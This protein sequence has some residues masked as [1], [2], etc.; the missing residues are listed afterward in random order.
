VAGPADTSTGARR[1]AGF[2][3]ATRLLGLAEG[4]TAQATGFA[5]V[6]G[7]E[8]AGELFA[9]PG[10]PTA[11][12]AANDL[13]ALG[14]IEAAEEAGLRCPEDLSVVGF[15]DMPFVDRFRPALTTIRIPEYDIGRRAAAMLLARI[16]QPDAPP[17][18]V[19][20]APELVVR[21]ST[22]PPGVRV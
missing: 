8:A 4:W 19:L 12:V 13:I 2:A 10:R 14:V 16:E 21:A 9:G 1:A 5:E 17:E 3:A 15:N 11:V 6:A 18:T 20:I 7:R 22:G